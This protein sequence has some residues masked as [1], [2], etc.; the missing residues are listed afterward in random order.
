MMNTENRTETI[1]ES[2]VDTEKCLE[3]IRAMMT[4]G[5]KSIRIEKHTFFYWG[6]SGA[7]LTALIAFLYQNQT[8]HM[9]TMTYTALCA[10]VLGLVGYLDYRKTREIRSAQD[11][12]ISLIQVKMTRIWWLLIGTAILFNIGLMVYG[13]TSA[14]SIWFVLIGLAIIIHAS[15]STQPL[16]KFG[17]ALIAMGIFLPALMPYTGLTWVTVS[18]YG[19]G[20]PLLGFM[21]YQS[22]GFWQA[23]KPY[24]VI[25]WLVIAVAPGYI[26]Y[27]VEKN[28]NKI[29]LPSKSI[30]L[31]EYMS[32]PS[33]Q[34]GLQ[35]IR[36]PAGTVV[37]LKLSA[38]GS[39][40]SDSVFTELPLVLKEPIEVAVEHGK[41]TGSYRVG[42]GAWSSLHSW[43]LLKIKHLLVDINPEKGLTLNANLG[44]L[45]RK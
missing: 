44:I 3:D 4:T 24:A 21:L 33:L 37:P 12:S 29:D 36:L 41:L 11:E 30:S 9:N 16:A 20:V 43:E 15:F 27:E 32:Q 26:A 17:F 14:Y 38:K 18:V 23:N 40:I 1:A 28:I 2:N 35:A 45:D 34:K 8:I 39:V 22:S 25:V 6:I 10:V 13:G 31:A 5:H 42:H 7:L 19:V